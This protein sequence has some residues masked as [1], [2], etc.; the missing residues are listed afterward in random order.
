STIFILHSGLKCVPWIEGIATKTTCSQG[1]WEQVNVA[2]IGATGSIGSL[3]TKWL[4]PRVS[5]IIMSARHIEKLERLKN[6]VREIHP[7]AVVIEQDA[8]KAIKEADIVITTTSAPEALLDI[9][10]FKPG[11]IVCDIAVPANVQVRFKERKDV[12]LFKGG[13][14]KLPSEVNFGISLGLP[15]GLV[16]G[17]IAETMLLT[18]EGRFENYSLGD[19]IDPAKLEEIAAIGRRHGFGVGW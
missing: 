4:C 10:E 15:K 7:R 12:K 6:L 3:C 18:F 11:A 17:C 13:L 1:T 2:I 5:K 16:Y 14:A 19:D 8:H 9:N